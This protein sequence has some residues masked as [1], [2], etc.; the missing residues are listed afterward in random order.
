MEKQLTVLVVDDEAMVRLLAKT[1]L[2]EANFNTLLA[3]S[4]DEAIEVLE[5]RDDIHA[6]ITD[7]QMPGSM[8][9]VRLAHAV[10]NR[11]PPIAIIV[12]SGQWSAPHSLPEKSR[13]FQKP[14]HPKEIIS[15]VHEMVN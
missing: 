7:V 12:M 8:D 15:A 10:C 5:R 14:F 9:G 3:S 11:W 4:A 13:F 2:D 6:I 1:F